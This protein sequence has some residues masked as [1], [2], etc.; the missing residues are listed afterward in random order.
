MSVM[1]VAMPAAVVMALA[2]LWAFVRS[3]QSGQFDDLDG[4]PRRM[5]QDDDVSK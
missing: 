2:A 5:L 3:A 1:W 4:P